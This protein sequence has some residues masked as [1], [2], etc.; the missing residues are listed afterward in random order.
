MFFV[1]QL[2]GGV[3]GWFLGGWPGAL[4]GMVIASTGVFIAD[5]LRAQLFIRWITEPDTSKPPMLHGLWGEAAYR[6]RRALRGLEKNAHDSNRRLEE[7]LEAIQA[8]PNG[9]VLLDPEGRI[10]WC[11]E[12]AAEHF[13]FDAERDRLQHIGNLVRQPAFAAYYAA[14]TYERDVK[15]IGNG[16]S[17]T[18]PVKLSA[19]L[20]PYG[21]GY[22]LLL[23]RDVT[24]LAQAEAMR[25]DFVANVSHEIRTPLTVL[26]GFVE[27]MQSLPLSE[28]ERSTYL[29]LM[30]SQSGRMETLVNDLLTLSQLE[31]SPLPGAGE[32]VDLSSL[33]AQSETEARGLSRLLHPPDKRP[34]TLQFAPAPDFM[35]AG[36]VS[37]LRSAASNLINNAVR[38][39][40]GG[41]TIDVR[42]ERLPDNRV[43]LAITDSGPGI[44]PEHLPRLAER[45]YRV[46]RSRSRESGGTGLG[47]AI[48]KHVAQ[49]HGGELQITSQLGKGSCFAL[50][51]PAQ[52][53][54]EVQA[55][56]SPN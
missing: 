47:L 40:P 26:A 34:Q 31:G 44:A 29:A 19:Q 16:D 6:A 49:R 48:T 12:A 38:Y 52:R 3:L 18:H 2:L 17:A 1:A 22:K 5:S 27:T 32:M 41:G 35:L 21:D 11:N 33:M 10:E 9:V 30:A 13:G 20:H 36:S 25:R 37:E 55:S 53:V 23:S 50:V 54:R 51:F 8:S 43:R 24:A 7:F 45:F 46:D 14:K 39:T 28:A 15:L 4:M 42:W 56:S